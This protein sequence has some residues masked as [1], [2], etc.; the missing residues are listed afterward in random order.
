MCALDPHANTWILVSLC[1]CLLVCYLIT[2][3]SEHSHGWESLAERWSDPVYTP[4]EVKTARELMLGVNGNWTRRPWHVAC[5]HLSPVKIYWS[6]AG[7][8][9]DLCVHALKDTSRLLF[10]S[11]L[12]ASR[13][14]VSWSDLQPFLPNGASSLRCPSASCSLSLCLFQLLCAYRT[15]LNS[16]CLAMGNNCL[17]VTTFNAYASSSPIAM[18]ANCSMD[19]L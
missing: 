18:K 16:F 14:N 9:W 1:V 15:P 13:V 5:C 8:L 11:D 19:A 4:V 6:S 10:S 2:E 12:W 17:R 7:R 3:L